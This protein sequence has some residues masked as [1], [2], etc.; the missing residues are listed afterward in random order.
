MEDGN[1]KGLESGERV[2]PESVA[3]PLEAW[4]RELERMLGK[5]TIQV[6]LL[7]E[8]L[9][10]AREKNAVG[11]APIARTNVLATDTAGCAPASIANALKNV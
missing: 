7:E 9:K 5:K 10:I 2:V 3:K 11:R 8:A 1:K 4:I 6:E